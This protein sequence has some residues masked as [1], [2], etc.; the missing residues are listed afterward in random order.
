[1]HTHILV[2][3]THLWKLRSSTRDAHNAQA[4]LELPQM[5]TH[6]YPTRAHL[7]LIRVHWYVAS[8]TSVLSCLRLYA[9][10]MDICSCSYTSL[11][12]SIASST[13]PSSTSFSSGLAS[14]LHPPKGC[15]CTPRQRR[16][17]VNRSS[18]YVWRE[19]Q[20]S[21]ST[22]HNLS[23]GDQSITYSPIFLLLVF[24]NDHRR[25][26]ASQSSPMVR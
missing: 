21:G 26:R 4:S 1:M 3:R 17:Q 11:C 14:R 12:T 25:P 24:I 7:A 9:P 22:N 5:C 15:L 16:E 8:S 23:L 10:L 20:R 19:T 13:Y 18:L 6:A 2:V